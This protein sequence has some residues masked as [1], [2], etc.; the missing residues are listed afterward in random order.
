MSAT[1]L[2]MTSVRADGLRAAFR[3]CGQ[4]LRTAPRTVGYSVGEEAHLGVT[5]LLAGVASKGVRQSDYLLECLQDA[6][7]RRV[8]TQ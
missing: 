1:R 5:A 3:D 4:Y 6:V 2:A 8:A 7:T